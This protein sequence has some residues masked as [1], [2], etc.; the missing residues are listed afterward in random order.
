MN[1]N[2]M[3]EAKYKHSYVYAFIFFKEIEEKTVSLVLFYQRLDYSKLA[4]SI[5]P[6]CYWRRVA[7]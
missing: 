6:T 4:T 2:E 1:I 3:K 5:I 7:V